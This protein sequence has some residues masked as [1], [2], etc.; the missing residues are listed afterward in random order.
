M[1]VLL[2]RV[3]GGAVVTDPGAVFGFTFGVGLCLE[4]TL[5]TGCSL[6]CGS[7]RCQGFFQ[8]KT[9]MPTIAIATPPAASQ[10]AADPP[11]RAAANAGPASAKID[12]A[13]ALVAFVRLSNPF[14]AGAEIACGVCSTTAGGTVA[15]GLDDPGFH[16][17]SG[18]GS[19]GSDLCSTGNSSCGVGLAGDAAWFGSLGLGTLS[20][21]SPCHQ[22]STGT[23]VAPGCDSSA[24][25]ASPVPGFHHP[26]ASG[27]GRPGCG[28]LSGFHQGLAASGVNMS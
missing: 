6:D 4:S 3:F 14:I 15:S 25:V 18:F 28:E 12:A 1:G 27:A 21:P 13:E 7:G 16:Q 24:S 26:S 2:V 11:R 8:T 10:R 9:P 19:G 5:A 20:E 23:V 22:P 17:L